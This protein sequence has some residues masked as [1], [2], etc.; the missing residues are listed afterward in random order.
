MKRFPERGVN[1]F[2]VARMERFLE[3]PAEFRGTSK[4][5]CGLVEAGY[6]DVVAG[7]MVVSE[8]GRGAIRDYREGQRKVRNW[9]LWCKKAFARLPWE[10]ARM[11]DGAVEFKCETEYGGRTA[12]M[13]CAVAV[14]RNRR[15]GGELAN[16]CVKDVG[17]KLRTYFGIGPEVLDVF[18]EK[19][20][21][22]FVADRL[23]GGE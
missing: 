15:P 9:A 13:H 14:L 7:K 4:M 20:R 3:N 19:H 2:E 8:R 17:E 1:G 18:R 23:A 6:A 21:E 16:V 22:V 12:K 11:G 5:N 10:H